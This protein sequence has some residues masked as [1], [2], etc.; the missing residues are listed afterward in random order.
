MR[1]LVL[2]VVVLLLAGCNGDVPKDQWMVVE[3]HFNGRVNTCWITENTTV[4]ATKI[5]FHPVSNK[6]VK[7]SLPAGSYAMVRIRE[8]GTIVVDELLGTKVENC[9]NGPYV[10]DQAG[11]A[12]R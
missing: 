8:R 9:R 12:Q 6:Q 10:V 4:Y 3:Y 5:M 1:A 11:I 2:A 7:I